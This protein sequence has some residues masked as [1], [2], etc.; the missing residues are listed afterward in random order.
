MVGDDG[1]YMV[2]GI[3]VL[4]LDNEACIVSQTNAALRAFLEVFYGPNG[5]RSAET[6]WSRFQDGGNDRRKLL[7]NGASGPDEEEQDEPKLLRSA[8]HLNW[9]ERR[10]RAQA[11]RRNRRPSSVFDQDLSV[12]TVYEQRKIPRVFPCPP[13]P[14][15]PESPSAAPSDTPSSVPSD[16]PS[17]S[18]TVS[19]MPSDMPSDTPSMVP[20]RS[21]QPS[22]SPL[23][24]IQPDTTSQPSSSEEGQTCSGVLVEVDNGPPIC[25]SP[26]EW[27]GAIGSECLVDT[28][29]NNGAQCRYGLLFGTPG[30]CQ[31]SLSKNA[32]CEETETCWDDPNIADEPPRCIDF[33]VLLPTGSEC[34][35][36]SECASWY[37]SDDG[38]CSCSTQSGTGCEDSLLPLESE[39]LQ[40]A[41]CAS[42]YCFQER[43]QCNPKT[44]AGCDDLPTASMEPTNSVSRNTPS[45]E[46][47][48]VTLTRR[49][50]SLIT[51]LLIRIGNLLAHS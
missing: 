31:C 13:A 48:D 15:A 36:Y 43:C 1:W 29:C 51:L 34:S 40:D 18:P 8:R 35:L 27:T 21:Q 33:S 49:K 38:V 12:G 24:E 10:K 23:I 26:E 39:C 20:T 25:V 17:L 5:D 11:K 19:F 41:E 32:G 47:R 50:R 6:F 3:T 16:V 7:H 22:L 28:D 30:S 45:T 9:D 4:P 37:C 2:E 44:N 14:P 46:I 42:D